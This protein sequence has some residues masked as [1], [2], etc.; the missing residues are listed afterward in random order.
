M[1]YPVL[2]GFMSLVLVSG[3]ASKDKACEDVVEAAKQVQACALLQKQIK[4]AEKKPVIRTELERRY[5]QDCIDV[6]Y[7][8]DDKQ[9]AI[10]DNKKQMKNIEKEISNQNKN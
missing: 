5:Q 10:C 6:R 3:C 1:K 7:Y 2:F 9:I 4:Q 8:R